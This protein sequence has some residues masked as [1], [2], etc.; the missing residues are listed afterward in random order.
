VTNLTGHKMISGYPEGRRV[1]INVRWLDS[2]G[3]LLPGTEV[4]AYGPIGRS[5]TD[6]NQVEHPVLSLLDLDDTVV[7]QATPGMDQGWAA[8]LSALGYPD[9][10]VLTYDRLTDAVDHTVGELKL[11]EPDTRYHTFHFALNNV[12][13]HDNRI[14]PFRMRYD[15]ARTRNTLPIPKD[16][17]GDPGTGGVYDHW[18]ENDFDVPPGAATAEVRLYYQQTSWEYIQFLWLENDTLGPFLGQEGINMLDAWANTGMC[19]PFEMAFRSIAVAA[20]TA[21]PGEAIYYGALESVSSYGY[22]GAECAVGLTGSATL[23]PGVADS[24]FFVIVANDGNEEGSYG[25]DSVG[26]QRPEDTGTP[27]CDHP[28]NLDGVICE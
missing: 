14:P 3:V 9:G 20:V 17:Y 16:Q 1:W 6:L 4:G 8:Q 18:D 25:R 22:D 10:M 19:Q 24:V 7:Y 26:V 21:V 15:D 2:G 27:S 11:E 13:V 23:S 12:V 28:Q 5:V